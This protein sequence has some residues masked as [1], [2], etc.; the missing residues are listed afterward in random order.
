M[1]AYV[2]RISLRLTGPEREMLETLCNV[3]GISQSDILRIGLRMVSKKAALDGKISN[4]LS[5]SFLKA[6]VETSAQ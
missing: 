4:D 5:T 3:E 2:E 1:D 6:S